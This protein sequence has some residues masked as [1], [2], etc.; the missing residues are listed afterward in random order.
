VVDKRSKE[1]IMYYITL[2]N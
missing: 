2:R 1:C